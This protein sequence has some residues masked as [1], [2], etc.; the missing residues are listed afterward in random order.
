MP[1]YAGA[2][3]LRAAGWVVNVKRI[4]RIWR[5]EGLKVPQKQPKRGRP[6]RNDGSFIWLRPDRPKHAWSQDSL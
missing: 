3:T 6:W 1:D 5:L 2:L 4:E